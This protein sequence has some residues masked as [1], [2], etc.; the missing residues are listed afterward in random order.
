MRHLIILMSSSS[1]IKW[2][3]DLAGHLRK[4]MIFRLKRQIGF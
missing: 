1:I 2:Q 4:W 3:N